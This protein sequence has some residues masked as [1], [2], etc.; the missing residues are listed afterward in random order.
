MSTLTLSRTLVL[1]DHPRTSVRALIAGLVTVGLAVAL[2]FNSQSILL[3][4]ELSLLAAGIGFV[5]AIA[6]GRYKGGVLI[7]ILT[8]ALPVF[9][10]NAAS[11]AILE[12]VSLN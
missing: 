3:G 5:L 6:V 11:T 12:P 10:L 8:A 7:G 4:P 2:R 1:G 9:A